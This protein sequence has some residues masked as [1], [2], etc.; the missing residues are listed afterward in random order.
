M[1]EMTGSYH[2]AL[3]IIAGLMAVS[4]LLPMLVSQPQSGSP[5]RKVEFRDQTR[6]PSLARKA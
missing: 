3:H 4:A 5:S 1:R 2:G 6:P